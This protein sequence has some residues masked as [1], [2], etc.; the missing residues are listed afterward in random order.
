[1]SITCL[2]HISRAGS[3]RCAIS[4]LVLA[5]WLALSALPALAR[6]M[7]SV[8]EWLCAHVFE[9]EGSALAFSR[10]GFFGLRL[11]EPNRPSQDITGLWRLAPDGVDL[12][13]YTLQ[14]M[15]LRMSV[16]KEAIH[17]SLGPAAHMTLVPVP[18]EAVT[19]EVTGLLERNGKG[20]VLTDAASGHAFAIAEAGDATADKFATMEVTIKNGQTESGRVIR[21]SGQVP[22]FFEKP[23]GRS[24]VKVFL[25]DIVGRFWLLPPIAGVDSAAMRFSKP[26]EECK[27]RFDVSGPGIRLEGNYELQGDRLSLGASPENIRNIRLAG[28]EGLLEA[29]IGDFTWQLLPSGMELT[30]KRRTLMMPNEL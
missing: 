22:R 3:A 7:R 5:L 23:G 28:A 9:G 13:L 19:F 30:G 16:G 14:D 25:E 6:D 21:H 17:A 18:T 26:A 10:D 15:R 12:T 24:G 29:V 4:A 8:A 11:N 20:A 2:N 1:M 27:G